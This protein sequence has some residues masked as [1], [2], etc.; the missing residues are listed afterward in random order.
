V[1]RASIPRL[2]VT[3]DDRILGSS[4]FFAAAS[5]VCAAGSGRIA[6]HVRGPHTSGRT[7][8]RL[9]RDLTPVARSSGTLLVVN[10]RIDV[11][12]A[13]GVEAVHLG[14]RSL[15][16]RQARDLLGDSVLIGR[17][18]HAV[19]EADELEGDADYLFFGNVHATESHPG[20]EEQGE[21]RLTLAAARATPVLGIGGVTVERVPSL[22]SAGAYGVAVLGGVWD[23]PD[24]SAAVKQYISALG[25]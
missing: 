13:E 17:S 6:F 12:L 16:V 2:H 22:L 9:V 25:G 19:E 7:V 23:A 10:D 24:P 4:D 14:D 15:D 11:A 3:T 8:Y 18:V 21:R 1:E 5:S 20:M